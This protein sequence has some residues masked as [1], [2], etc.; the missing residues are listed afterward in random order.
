MFSIISFIINLFLIILRPVYS[1]RIGLIPYRSLGRISGNMEYYLR[2]QKYVSDKKKGIDLLIAGCNPVNHQIL[3]MIER[4]TKLIQND[5][6]WELLKK[7]QDNILKQHE[8][9]RKTLDRFSWIDF[10]HSGFLLEWEI[11]QTIGPQLNFT[12]EEIVDGKRILVDLGIP[13]NREYVCIHAR[14]SDYTD[15]PDFI[16]DPQDY[17]SYN[18]FRDCDISS[19]M[20]A[21][22]WLVEQGLYVV[23]VGHQ[24]KEEFSNGDERIIDYAY[25]ARNKMQNPEFAD[26]FLQSHCKFFVG[27]TAGIYYLSHIFDIPMVFVNMVPLAE[28]GRSNHDLFILKK[29]WNNIENRYMTF[30][31]MVLRGA[32]WN[33]LWHDTQKAIA[34]EG[35]EIINNSSEEILELTKEMFLRLQGVWV[36]EAIH[37]EFQNR[38]RNVFPQNHP[39]RYFPGYIGSEFL[40]QNEDM[41]IVN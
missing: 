4:R 33:R 27:C 23:R 20:P 16:R 1:L 30:H 28:S 8:N 14:D 3:T 32:D 31:E 39:M 10:S 21:A 29:Y 13:T 36:D 35:I 26:V 18:D 17:F 19:Y 37:Q 11:W 7:I 9:S 15:S 2:N 5:F 40:L 38:F 41:L 24:A 22:E 25:H 12:N 34:D 6:I